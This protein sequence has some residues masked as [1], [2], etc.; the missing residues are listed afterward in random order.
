MKT[1]REHSLDFRVNWPVCKINILLS[2]WL[3]FADY[4]LNAI[5]S[6]FIGLTFGPDCS[7]P[8]ATPSCL[9]WLDGSELEEN[10]LWFDDINI[11]D[12]SAGGCFYATVSS[13][14]VTI[15]QDVPCSNHQLICQGDCPTGEKYN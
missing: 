4:N 14:V 8:G 12:V 5:D 9:K 10:N 15:I 2:L 11:T 13:G 3:N 1:R 7:L 6:F